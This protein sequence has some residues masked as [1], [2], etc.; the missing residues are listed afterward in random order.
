MRR[1]TARA[2]GSAINSSSRPDSSS[3]V[4]PA[5]ARPCG[6]RVSAASSMPGNPQAAYSHRRSQTPGRLI[7]RAGRPVTAAEAVA[8]AVEVVG[9]VEEAG[10]DIRA[11]QREGRHRPFGA[12]R[13]GL[14]IG[15]DRRH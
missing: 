13:L 12:Q 1:K 9:S 8:S 2:T 10:G 7:Q 15:A 5:S 3:A 11:A 4:V 14:D 6:S